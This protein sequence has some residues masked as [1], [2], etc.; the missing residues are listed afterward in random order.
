QAIY[1]TR[2]VTL[3]GDRIGM[4]QSA[5]SNALK[6]MR[7]RFCDPLFVRTPEGMVPTPLAERLI[8]AI[9]SGLG[10]IA[11]AIDQGRQFD[12]LR[13]DR[14][15]RV[16]INDIGQLVMMPRL[17]A[18]AQE[19]APHVRFETVDASLA[20]ARQGMMQGQIDLAVGS[21]KPMGQTFYQQRL[22]DETF[23][24]LMS[25]TS[26][27]AAREMSADDY[28]SARH[29]GYR[30]SGGTDTELQN[31]LNRAGVLGQRNVVLTAAHSL[32]LSAIVASSDLLL[33]A[34]GRLAQA[35]IAARPDLRM[36]PTPFE[37]GPFAIR[38]Q[39]HER[40]QL[41][42]GN[43][44][45]RNLFFSLFHEPSVR[46]VVEMAFEG[47]ARQALDQTEEEHA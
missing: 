22:F 31:T 43:R 40:F 20:D 18:A 27:L 37:V 38:Q 6:R 34:P 45:L 32:G 33:T 12:P 47:P 2:S 46:Q 30:P 7:E 44:W 3:A 17:L 10:Q 24:V 5:A 42:N 23:V 19:Q 11:Q 26:P 25:S 28:L 14:T 4:T 16:A 36:C 35:M 41:D 8:G 29:L 9:D 15:F 13:S 21:W 1:V 39:W